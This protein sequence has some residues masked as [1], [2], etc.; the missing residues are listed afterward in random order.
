MSI[1]TAVGSERISRIVGYQLTKGD[2]RNQSP[3]LPQRIAILGEANSANQVG[4]ST[5]PV[6]ITSAQQAGE[7]YGFGSPI[8][9]MMRILRP[10]N[11][12]GI[13]G[14]PTIVYPQADADSAVSA[15]RIITA[16]GTATAN[17]THTLIINGRRSIDG[18][19]YDVNIVIG[20]TPTTIAT[21]IADVVANALG[22]PAN[23]LDNVG[24]VTIFAKWKGLTSNDLT[25]EV[26]T[27]GNTLGITYAV[28]VGV[29]GSG[30]P[31]VTTSLGMFG[32]EWNTIVVN[33][34][35]VSSVLD[36]L[37]AFNGIPSDLPTGRYQGVIFKPFVALYG[38]TSADTSTITDARKLQLTNASC[39]AP[40]SDGWP[41]EAA[42]NMALLFGRV[43]QDTPNLDVNAK[44]Y[45]DMP[46]PRDSD[47]GLMASY[48]NRDAIVKKGGSTVDLVS[49]KY[50]VQD[51]VTTYHP[52]GEN[53]PQYRYPRNLMLD[54]NVRYAIYVLEQLYVVDHQISNDSDIVE[55]QN[56]IK[57]KQWI[58]TL[59]AEAISLVKRGLIVDAPFTQDSIEVEIDGT[60][61]DR[62]NTFFRYKRS[63]IARISS[64]TAEAGFNFG[65]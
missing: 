56:V 59:Q 31:T 54:F 42:A 24:T 1:S 22:C 2:F 5:D 14:I 43:A 25:V 16:T 8:Y 17:G 33:P 26:D 34:Y 37:E 15:T 9:T 39:P 35:T 4:L 50:Q 52:I 23:S 55:A 48:D 19:S 36:E 21:K 29:A 32:N 6:E 12:S 18:D 38:D 65:G 20:D 51:F 60:N 57:P 49:G 40:N 45:A 47:I 30:T 27:N 58:Q 46:I 10:V 53:P 11:G 61:P 7:L 3:N 62:L 41:M 28:A 63:G 64:T 44:F 13:G